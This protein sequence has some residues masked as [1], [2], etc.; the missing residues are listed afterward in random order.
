MIHRHHGHGRSRR[1][2]SARTVLVAVPLTVLTVLGAAC[3]SS[4]STSTTTTKATTTTTTSATNA[5]ADTALAKTQLLPA[6]AYPAGWTG[7]GSGSTNTQASFFGGTDAA[8][9]AA[10][11]HCLGIPAASVNANPAE[12]ADQEYDDPNSSTTVTDT[13]D[14]YPSPAQALV[15]VQAAASP[16][17]PGCV[18]SLIVPGKSQQIAQQI[19]EGA[20]VG[21][22]TVTAATVPPAGVHS[23]ALVIAVPFT[24]QGV[25]G[26]IS[27]EDVA[28]QKGRSESILVFTGT[29][30]ASQSAT[31]DSLV[32]AAGNQL[33]T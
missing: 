10:M 23:A 16:K 3:S 8:G 12:A 13:V 20:T 27:V 24:Y 26:T 6:S 5:A 30:L 19:G 9:V 29:D 11:V 28:V 4:S 14:V 25:S 15:D 33:T 31:I 1:S 7:Q 22:V 32:T 18:N 21:K 17:A 2:A